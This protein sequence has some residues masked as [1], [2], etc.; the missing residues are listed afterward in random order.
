MNAEGLGVT[1]IGPS[2]VVFILGT[3]ASGPQGDAMGD[4]PAWVGDPR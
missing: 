3:R 2:A 4:V 1:R